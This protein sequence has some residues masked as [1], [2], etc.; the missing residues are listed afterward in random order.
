MTTAPE[1]ITP[2]SPVADT[3]HKS[4]PVADAVLPVVDTVRK[5]SLAKPRQASYREPAKTVR[6]APVTDADFHSAPVWPSEDEEEQDFS[7][8]KYVRCLSEIGD[9]TER[10]SRRLTV[11]NLGPETTE[12]DLRDL[13][14][15]FIMYDR[16]TPVF[17][18]A[19]LTCSLQTKRG[20]S[21][22]PKHA[23]ASHLWLR[24]YQRTS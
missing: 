17:G 9:R 11:G 8:E 23:E 7:N 14:E 19:I 1:L 3:V 2:S 15:G 6:F 22:G 13:F 21:I 5:S 12:Q 10:P 4:L 16:I 24:D 18:Y 20:N